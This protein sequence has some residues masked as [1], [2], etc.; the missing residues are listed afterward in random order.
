MDKELLKRSF[1]KHKIFDYFWNDAVLDCFDSDIILDFVP[2][3]Y[4]SFYQKIFELPLFRTTGDNSS[5]VGI[6]SNII[7]KLT[8][9]TEKLFDINK[10]L[11][12][13]DNPSANSA[14]FIKVQIKNNDNTIIFS[15]QF[16]LGSC[17]AEKIETTSKYI[18]EMSVFY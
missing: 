2:Q 7:I 11:K 15:T 9:M 16:N 5:F 12:E 17:E 18:K 13:I 3:E 14:I 6:H 4:V 1:N 8:S 10:A